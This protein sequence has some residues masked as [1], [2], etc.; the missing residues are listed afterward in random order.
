MH[1]HRLIK[2]KLLAI[3]VVLT[4]KRQRRSD[5]LE[6]SRI[7]GVGFC[8]NQVAVVKSENNDTGKDRSFA[9]GGNQV[10]F[11]YE[12]SKNHARMEGVGHV[13]FHPFYVCFLA[14]GH[15]QNPNHRPA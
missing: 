2:Q 10:A 5:I 7:Q 6:E 12:Q 4:D 1:R 15:D 13:L 9:N 3:T 14:G 11:P 8:M